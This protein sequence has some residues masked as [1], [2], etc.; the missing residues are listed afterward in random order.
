MSIRYYDD[1]QGR[2]AGKSILKTLCKF[3]G[4]TSDEGHIPN[5]PSFYTTDHGDDANII[6]E[7]RNCRNS[8]L[9]HEMD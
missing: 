6:A 1:F 7:H 3:W 2:A 9:P 8:H 4:D 5:M